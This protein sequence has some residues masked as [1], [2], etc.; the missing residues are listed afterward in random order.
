MEAERALQFFSRH[1]PATQGGEQP[2]LDC[3]QQTLGRPERHADFHDPR[4]VSASIEESSQYQYAVRSTTTRLRLRI[5]NAGVSSTSR[6]RR[7]RM[8]SASQGLRRRVLARLEHLP[9]REMDAEAAVTV[10]R[11]QRKPEVEPQRHQ[12]R[13][14]PDAESGAN[15]ELAERKVRGGQERIPHID[16]PCAAEPARDRKSKLT[17]QYRGEPFHPGRCRTRSA[18]TGSPRDTRARCSCRQ[19]GKTGR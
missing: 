15:S 19:P 13:L 18:P 17:V 12:R 9:D 5:A 4:G 7:A 2:E 8:V 6:R 10:L 14:D 3:R 16:E 11:R 1:R